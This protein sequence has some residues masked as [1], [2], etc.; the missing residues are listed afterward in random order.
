MKRALTVGA[1]AIALGTGFVAGGAPAMA[2]SRATAEV[3]G[4]PA[5][6]TPTEIQQMRILSPQVRRITQQHQP[7]INRATDSELQGEAQRALFRDLD[8]AVRAQGLTVERYNRIAQLAS[9]YPDLSRAIDG[10][11]VSPGR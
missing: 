5:E 11:D 6:V 8:E 4:I 2:Q 7:A 9:V 10:Q 3:E 1:M